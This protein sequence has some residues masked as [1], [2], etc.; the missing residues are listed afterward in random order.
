M[1]EIIHLST[2]EAIAKKLMGLVD[3]YCRER[4]SSNYTNNI[5]GVTCKNCRNR[6]RRDGLVE[7]TKERS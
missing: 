1:K 5:N 2:R 6:L 7:L 4:P 3:I